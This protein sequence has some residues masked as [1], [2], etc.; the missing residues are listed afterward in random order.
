M[1]I[2]RAVLYLLNAGRH[3]DIID[4]EGRTS[5]D[6]VV[7]TMNKAMVDIFLD[8]DRRGCNPPRLDE[9]SIGVAILRDRVNTV[10]WLIKQ[11]NATTTQL[12]GQA[13]NLGSSVPTP[14]PRG[15]FLKSAVKYRAMGC[16]RHLAP[17]LQEPLAC[18]AEYARA[19]HQAAFDGYIEGARFLLVDC[20]T[21]IN[22]VDKRGFTALHWACL[23]RESERVLFLLNQ[24]IDPN[25]RH[26]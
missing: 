12:T 7:D 23:A 21:P 16:V 10:G 4:Y 3:P 6:I 26:V 8:Y 5:I 13:R 22:G 14:G 20:G 2:A 11:H 9:T 1:D 19:L 17:T 24:G 18:K 15:S 25:L